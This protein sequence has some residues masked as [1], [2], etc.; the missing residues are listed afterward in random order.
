MPFIHGIVR[1]PRVARSMAR[2]AALAAALE[3][4]ASFYAGTWVAQNLADFLFGVGVPQA[5]LIWAAL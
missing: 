3:I 4:G 1:S 2:T 5:V